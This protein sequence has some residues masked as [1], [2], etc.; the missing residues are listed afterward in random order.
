MR[1]SIL[2]GCLLSVAAFANDS[3]FHAKLASM[4]KGK[5]HAQEPRKMKKILAQRK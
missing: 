2:A 3:P 5:G 4:S 1:Y